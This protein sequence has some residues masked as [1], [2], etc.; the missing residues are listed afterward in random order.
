VDNKEYFD[1]WKSRL[2]AQ[3]QHQESDIDCVEHILT[4]TRIFIHSTTDFTDV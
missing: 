2:A 1:K 3:G 4:H